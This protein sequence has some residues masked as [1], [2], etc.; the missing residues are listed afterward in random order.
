MSSSTDLPKIIVIVGPTAVG[1]SSLAVSLAREFNGEIISADSRQVYKGLNLG[2]GKITEK[3]MS[4][5]PHHLLNI[6]EPNIKF[7]V[8]DYV[9]IAEQTIKEIIQRKKIPIICGG[10]GFYIDALVDGKIIPEVTA[11]HELRAE[12]ENK[13]LSELTT[14]LGG[15]DPERLS[16]IKKGGGD[17]NKRRLIRAIEIATTLGKVP[18]IKFIPKYEALFIGLN[19]ENSILKENINL[20]LLERL[21]LGMVEEV[22]NLHI[23][24]LSW[25][26]MEELGLEYKYIAKY[27]QKQ[28][29]EEEMI[30]QLKNEINHYAKRQMTWFKK[31]KKIKWF[32]PTEMEMIEKEVKSFLR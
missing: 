12:L 21:D 27:L 20:R 1:K 4:G 28:I 11:N 14:K 8:Y 24:G 9:K 31:N 5:I 13:Q 26:R 22:S 15:L 29:K 3:E 23:N 2:T 19:I 16:D 10:T 18:K 25:Q 6:A 7:S 17:K 32:E 30:E